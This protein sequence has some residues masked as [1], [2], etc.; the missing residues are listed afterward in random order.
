M[1]AASPADTIS[2]HFHQSKSALDLGFHENGEKLD[3]LL[4]I[5]NQRKSENSFLTIKSVNVEGG[6]SPEGSVSINEKLSRNRAH[7][8]YDW[9]FE[10]IS[11]QDSTVNFKFL[12]RDWEGLKRSVEAD[13]KVPDRAEVL[14]FID[15]AIIENK[16]NNG[17]Q[18]RL[19]ELKRL[20]NGIPYAYLYQNLFPDLRKSSVIISYS[21]NKV[22][23]NDYPKVS[24]PGIILRTELPDITIGFIDI[25]NSISVCRPFYMG[26]KTNLLYDILAI[27]NVAVEFYIGKNWSIGADWMYGWWDNNRTHYY[28]RAYGGGVTLRRWF[29]RKANEKPLTGHHLGVYAGIVTYDFELGGTGYMGGI[30]KGTLWN[31][32]NYM[33]GIEYGYSLPVARRF[34]ID[35]TLGIGYMGGKYIKY[36]P[37]K[38]VYQWESTNHLRWF[39][40]TK[41][42]IS[43]V[44]LIGCD[45]YN[46][47]K[48]GLK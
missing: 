4:K 30:P 7:N 22:P 27:P 41:A 5:I 28:W 47:P 37:L 18:D 45:N 29:G 17:G 23:I 3:S 24:D 11:I 34:N 8:I 20:G 19:Q 10:R 32:C 31:R 42:E 16:D 46:R 38:D 13:P 15:S 35:F 48:G 44:W 14:E 21:S 33:A 43:L 25:E 36:R 6:A 2:I 9:F 40:P 12:G 1:M 26:L 39:G